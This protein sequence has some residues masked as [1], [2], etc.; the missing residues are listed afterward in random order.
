MNY[1]THLYWVLLFRTED[2][3]PCA[4]AIVRANSIGSAMNRAE[5]MFDEPL[6]AERAVLIPSKEDRNHG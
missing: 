6:V 3:S 2:F 1:R 5:S 4:G